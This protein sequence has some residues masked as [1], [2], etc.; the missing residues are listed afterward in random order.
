MVPATA[1]HTQPKRYGHA[2]DGKVGRTWVGVGT[3]VTCMGSEAGKQAPSIGPHII[4]RAAGL[5]AWDSE[6]FL[7]GIGKMMCRY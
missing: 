4:R 5:H 2:E 1:T 7:F 6:A 3:V